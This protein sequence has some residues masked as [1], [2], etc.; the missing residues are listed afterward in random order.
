[1]KVESMTGNSGKPVA[2]Q[3]VI[4]GAEHDGIDGDFFQSYD[5]LV[6]FRGYNGTIVLDSGT[7]DYS[8][9]TAKYRNKFLNLDTKEIERRIK[10]GDIKLDNL[11]K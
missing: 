9:T 11:N 8:R 6:A 2:N 3:F 4:N 5:S 1:M 7:W 10:S